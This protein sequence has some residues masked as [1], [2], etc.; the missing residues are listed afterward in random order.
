MVL[1]IS[2]PLHNFSGPIA[3][4][5]YYQ[6]QTVHDIQI[7]EHEKVYELALQNNKIPEKPNNPDSPKTGDDSNMTLW[8]VLMGVSV[9]SLIGL[10]VSRKR[11][12]TTELD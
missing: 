5:L 7:R 12:K 8:L 1:L 3:Q 4:F 6:T 2:K 10:A 11:K 9:A